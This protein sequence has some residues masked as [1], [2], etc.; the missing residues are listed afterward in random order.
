MSEILARIACSAEA[1]EH[2]S[3]LLCYAILDGET[4]RVVFLRQVITELEKEIM[5]SLVLFVAE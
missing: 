4:A 5:E 2:V 1:C 3:M